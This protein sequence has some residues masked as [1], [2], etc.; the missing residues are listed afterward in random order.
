MVWWGPRSHATHGSS[1]IIDGVAWVRT[2]SS[3]WAHQMLFHK[4]DIL[5]RLQAVLGVK[6]IVDIRIVRGYHRI[7]P[8]REPE[9]E[10]PPDVPLEQT[11]LAGIDGCVDV[12]EDPALRESLRRAM[13]SVK[14]RQKGLLQQ[15]WLSCTECGQLTDD[16]ERLCFLCRFRQR[17]GCD[18]Q[19]VTAM[20]AQPW[21]TPWDLR[22]AGAGPHLQRA[23]HG[24][25]L[26]HAVAV[27]GHAALAASAAQG[28]ASAPEMVEKA[29]QYCVY[30]ADGRGR[31]WMR[32][33]TTSI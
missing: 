28:R 21:A 11:D 31:N 16:K 2:S 17:K 18:M 22:G 4:A 7:A 19:V 29:H 8:D 27:A 3:A 1:R 20:L 12:V 23:H 24:A 15:G 5:T 33:S 10:A 25:R 14:K 6:R 9:V 13:T 30:A 26:D 32:T